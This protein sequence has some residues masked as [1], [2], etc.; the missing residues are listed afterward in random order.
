MFDILLLAAAAVPALPSITVSPTAN[1]FVAKVETFDARYQPQLDAEID[2]RAGELCAGKTVRWGEFKSDMKIERQLGSE[3]PQVSGFSR[4]F[5]CVKTVER[6]FAPAPSDWKPSVADEADVRQAFEAY[7]ARRDAGDFL[8]ARAMFAPEAL[9]EDSSWSKQ[10]AEF[11][12][13]VGTGT[14]RITGISWYVNPEG[15]PHPGIYAAV[16]FAGKFARTHFYCGYL[17]FFRTGAGTYEITREE[18]NHF[19]RGKEAADPV[20]LAQMRAVMC[21]GE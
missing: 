15:A 9:A 12:K 4:A 14:R 16:D 6:T 2:R 5:S 18:Q 21:R 8:T 7:Y 1:G 10:M 20:Q 11:N 13:Q 3:P 19:D 17:V